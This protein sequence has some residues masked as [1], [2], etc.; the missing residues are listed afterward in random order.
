MDAALLTTRLPVPTMKPGPKDCLDPFSLG[1]D[2]T[3]SLMSSCEPFRLLVPTAEV[4]REF[5]IGLSA[6]KKLDRLRRVVGVGGSF[7][8]DSLV[9]SLSDIGTCAVV[10]IGMSLCCTIISS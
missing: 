3:F 1:I 10:G 9:L 8:M 7:D 6:L 4:G 5:A 2:R